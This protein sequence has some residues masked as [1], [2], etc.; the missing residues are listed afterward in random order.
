MKRTA[1]FFLMTGT[2][3]FCGPASMRAQA[4]PE[5]GGH[6]LQFWTAGG[7]GTNGVNQHTG[8]WLTGARYGWILTGPHGPGFLR[9]QFEYAVDAIPAFVVYQRVNTAFGVGLDPIDLVW[10]FQKHGRIVPY[11]ELSGGV[12][13][14]NRD[15]PPGTSRVNF[16]SSGGLG[17]HFLFAKLKWNAD[18]RFMHISNAG[19]TSG[20]PGINT[21]QLRV[22]IGMFTGGRH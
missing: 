6:E 9:G 10:N 22:G 14:T 21:V 3:S 5:A 19:L 7:H 8:V 2:L 11:A 4:G 18:V 1:L 20:N 15:V 13:F 16:T 17:L 12:L